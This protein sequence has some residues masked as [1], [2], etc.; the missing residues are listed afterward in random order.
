MNLFD[1]LE[2]ALDTFDERPLGPVDSAALS[3]FCMVR[4]EGV[5]PAALWCGSAIARLRA[6]A[7]RPARFSDLLRAE[8]YDGLF[9]GLAPDG[10][11]RELAALV[12]SPRF[13][14]I[15]LRDYA[16]RF[17]E[18]EHVQFSRQPVKVSSVP[19]KPT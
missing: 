14:D 3:Q 9:C 5:I 1:Y 18:A 11:K 8:H 2:S 19:R 13:R 10:V 7:S 6:W 4:G 12:A 16:S 15:E 17:D